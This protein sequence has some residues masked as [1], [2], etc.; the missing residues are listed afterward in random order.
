MEAGAEKDPRS[1]AIARPVSTARAVSMVSKYS[2]CLYPA[3]RMSHVGLQAQ[4]GYQC[5]LHKE[6]FV[7]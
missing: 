6:C 2:S 5:R 4:F 3:Q 1:S 7:C